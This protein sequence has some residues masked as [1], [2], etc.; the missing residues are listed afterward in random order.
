[1]YFLHLVVNYLNL[2]N[3]EKIE[4]VENIQFE[5]LTTSTIKAIF[6]IIKKANSDN[7]SHLTRNRRILFN[8]SRL[9]SQ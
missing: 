8:G 6:G 7:F 3:L 1:M 2:K 9:N 5:N 4:R